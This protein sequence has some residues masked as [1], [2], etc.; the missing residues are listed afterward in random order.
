VALPWLQLVRLVPSIL[1]VSRELLNR[2]KRTAGA[3]QAQLA[4]VSDSAL[5]DRIAAL[6]ENERRQ[7][8]LVSQMAEQH[9]VLAR[10]VTMLHTRLVRLG[11]V[12]AVAAV[13]A[14]GAVA[15]LLVR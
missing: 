7:A 8:E 5:A 9:A 4:P 14:L 11:I 10:A 1:D 6:E 12:A 15:G 13:A 3:D 2:T